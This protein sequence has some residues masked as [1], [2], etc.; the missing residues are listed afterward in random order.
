MYAS[1]NTKYNRNNKSKIATI[2]IKSSGRQKH[3]SQSSQVFAT[4]VTKKYASMSDSQFTGHPDSKHQPKDVNNCM[5]NYSYQPDSGS[6][7]SFDSSVDSNN[8]PDFVT[9]KYGHDSHV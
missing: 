7:F 6:D 3:Y 5:D 8:V 1:P 2:R 9:F 4:E